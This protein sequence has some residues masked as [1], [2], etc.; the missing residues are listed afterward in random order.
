M[1]NAK[2]CLDSIPIINGQ[3]DIGVEG[4]IKRVREARAECREKRALLRLI[5]TQR[6]IG[7]TERSIRYI[8]IEN[9]E[10]LFENLEKFV[11]VSITS[12][13]A[14]EKLQRTRQNFNESVH[15][16]VKRFRLNLNELIYALQH[17]FHDPIRRAVAIDLETERATKVFILNLKP[18]IEIRTS[19]ARPENLK[20]AQ[21]TTFE[22]ELFIE[23]IER[24]KNIVRERTMSQPI[25]RAKPHFQGT[26]NGRRNVVLGNTAHPKPIDPLTGRKATMGRPPP[27]CFK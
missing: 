3:D 23:E 4:F 20:A 5:L 9:Y 10:D 25:A 14:R 22:A 8:G 18:E 26:L 21:D 2:S 24:N 6:I 1:Y 27:K 7:E 15:R 16:Y 17:E 13:G 11:S 12:N 19:A